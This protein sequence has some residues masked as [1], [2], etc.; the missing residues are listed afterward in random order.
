MICCVHNVYNS[1]NSPAVPLPHAS[2][3]RLQQIKL[4]QSEWHSRNAT[5]AADNG[6]MIL[7]HTLLVYFTCPPKSHSLIVTAPLVTFLILKPTVGIISS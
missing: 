3:T 1:L 2:E 7:Q 5:G 6:V 4:G